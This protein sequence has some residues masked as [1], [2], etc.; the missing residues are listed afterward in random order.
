MFTFAK[1]NKL[2][3]YIFEYIKVKFVKNDHLPNIENV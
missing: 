2:S 3:L 1:C